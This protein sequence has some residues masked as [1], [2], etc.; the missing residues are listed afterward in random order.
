MSDTLIHHIKQHNYF[1]KLW[2]DCFITCN[3]FNI[4][5]CIDM[6]SFRDTFEAIILVT[7]Y[8]VLCL[9]NKTVVD[10]IQKHCGTC[11]CCDKSAKHL[12]ALLRGFFLS[13]T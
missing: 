5:C 7:F 8:I 13:L 3:V 1:L 9:Q 2:F 12:T 4:A 11:N 10:R 6:D